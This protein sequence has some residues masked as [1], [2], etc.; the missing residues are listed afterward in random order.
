[1]ASR[2]PKVPAKVGTI[3]MVVWL[4]SRKPPKVGEKIQYRWDEHQRWQIGIVTSVEPLKFDRWSE[5]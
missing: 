1:M 5:A 4:R 3:P 2:Y